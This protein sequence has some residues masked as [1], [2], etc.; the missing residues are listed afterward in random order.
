MKKLLVAVIG[1]FII[2]ILALTFYPFLLQTGQFEIKSAQDFTAVDENDIEFSLSDF[3]GN[4][5]LIHIT[6]LETPLCIECEEEMIGQLEQLEKLSKLNDDVKIITLNIRKNPYSTTGKSIAEKTYG[7]NISWN[8]VEDYEPFQ[9][10]GF[11]QEKTYGINIS[12]NWVEDYEPFQFAGFYQEYWI[13]N[14]A[15][16]NPTIILIDTNQS[17][18]GVYLFPILQLF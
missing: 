18:V 2:F 8:W 3:K 10:A 13:Y 15:F 12:W 9:F 1:A 11:Y 16:S 14:G 6:G 7:I 4:V 5:T 17:I